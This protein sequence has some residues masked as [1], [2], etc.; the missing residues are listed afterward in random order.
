MTMNPIRAILDSLLSETQLFPEKFRLTS[1][2]HLSQPFFIFIRAKGKLSDQDVLKRLGIADFIRVDWVPD[3]GSKPYVLVTDDSEWIHIMDNWSYSLWH[4]PEVRDCIAQIGAEFETYACSIGDADRGFD[5]VYYL[6]GDLR[7]KYVVQS[8]NYNDRVVTEDIGDP[9]SGE[10]EALRHKDE[11]G[12]VL[13]LAV[14]LGIN[15]QHDLSRIRI[16][17]KDPPKVLSMPQR[18]AI[19][20]PRKFTRFMN[21]IEHRKATHSKSPYRDALRSV[22]RGFRRD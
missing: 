2:G 18:L 15:I 11:W 10:A 14:S 22:I 16:Y 13:E 6:D 7:R 12:I 5:F 20:F 9:L 1:R 4:D 17:Q 3:V 19:A 8:P 21:I